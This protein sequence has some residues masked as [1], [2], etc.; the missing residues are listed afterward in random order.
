MKILFYFLAISFFIF[1]CNPKIEKEI[2][3]LPA[4]GVSRIFNDDSVSV[5][6]NKYSN[7]GHHKKISESYY[8]R[9]IEIED[10]DPDKATYLYKRS[11]TLFPN[12]NTYLRL[13]EILLKKELYHESFLLYYLLT[14]NSN[15]IFPKPGIEEYFRLFLSAY[16]S[17]LFKG[18]FYYE[19]EMSGIDM[20]ELKDRL[21]SSPNFKMDRKS[22]EFNE[23]ELQFLTEEEIEDFIK[24]NDNVK[25]ILTLFKDTSNFFEINSTSVRKFNY[26]DIEDEDI[27]DIEEIVT[28]HG[29]FYSFIKKYESDGLLSDSLLQD[30][31]YYN[32]NCNH[33]IKISDSVSAIIYALDNSEIACPLDM[34]VVK[35][36]L[37]TVNSKG[38]KLDSKTVAWQNGEILMTLRFLENQFQITNHKRYWKKSFFQPD[39]DN[40]IIKIEAINTESYQ[41]LPDGKIVPLET[42]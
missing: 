16:N 41:I 7:S 30:N 4:L 13:G 27:G 37:I 2:V 32:Y 35:H 31:I 24:T 17:N 8:L 20:K 19:A 12:Y 38:D 6:L 3:E 1:S 40:E 25:L 21:L 29:I 36:R 28:L 18:Y 11:L 14:S 23:F 39:F 42:L 22:H 34:R 26:G 5:F 10:S 9:G 33:L 15:N